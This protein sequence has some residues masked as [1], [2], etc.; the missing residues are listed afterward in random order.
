MR[1]EVL[2][3]AR[4]ESGIDSGAAPRPLVVGNVKE[5]EAR[6]LE[7]GAS[8]LPPADRLPPKQSGASDLRLSNHNVIPSVALV[9]NQL[10]NQVYSRYEF[11]VPD[12]RP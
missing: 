5:A 1:K 3:S 12:H 6:N 10:G 9:T 4:N 7:L 8:L 2:K 11:C